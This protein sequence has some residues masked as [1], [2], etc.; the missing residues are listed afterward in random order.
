MAGVPT[1][2]PDPAGR[3]ALHYAARDN[4]L[5]LIRQRLADGVGA[6]L[7]DRHRWRPLHFAVQS[8]HP[9][10]ARLLLE[11]GAD[12]Q[13]RLDNTATPLHL[14]VT[15]WHVSPEA[16]TGAVLQC[17]VDAGADKTA[18]TKLGLTPADLGRHKYGFPAELLRILEA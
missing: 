7:P 8:G 1:T 17:L 3:D 9:A 10:A 12:V 18:T 4:D 16:R 11:A 15:N 14:A 13:A 6:D 5:D 2:G